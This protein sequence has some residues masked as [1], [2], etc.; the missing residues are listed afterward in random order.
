MKTIY[1]F[2]SEKA[3]VKLKNPIDRQK[4]PL[5]LIAWLFEVL[6]ADSNVFSPL[7][8]IDVQ[9]GLGPKIEQATVKY[10][11]KWQHKSLNQKALLQNKIGSC[12]NAGTFPHHNYAN[13]IVVDCLSCNKMFCVTWFSSPNKISKIYVKSK[14]RFARRPFLKSYVYMI[15][16]A[17]KNWGATF[18]RQRRGP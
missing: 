8:L 7:S 6:L 17:L 14:S 1:K 2:R 11:Q 4:N 16:S 15:L 9:I 10:L 5:A 18:S 12:F 3:L 13:L